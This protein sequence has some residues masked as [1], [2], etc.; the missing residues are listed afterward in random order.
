LVFNGINRAG[1]YNPAAAPDVLDV[2]VTSLETQALEPIKA[3]EEMRGNA[4]LEDGAVNDRLV[5]QG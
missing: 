4:Y 3:F 2:R 5:W 1:Q